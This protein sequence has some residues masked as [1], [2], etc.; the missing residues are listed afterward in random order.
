M[1]LACVPMTVPATLQ[2]PTPV[3]GTSWQ[4]PF[5]FEPD[6]KQLP[7]QQS[8]FSKQTSL[9]CKQYEMDVHFPPTQPPEQQSAF[10]PHALPEPR[11]PVVIAVHLPPEQRPL[12]HWTFDVHDAAVGLSGRHA[13]A[14]QVL[15]EPQ[16]PEQ[17]SEPV[18]HVTP[19][20]KHGPVR[21]PQTFG[22]LEPQMPPPGQGPEPTP[23]VRR[24]PQPSGTKPQ[25][26]PAQAVA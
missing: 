4:V 9:T 21:V 10:V 23:H 20:L 12:Q 1:P 18:S 7:V 26:R 17:Q 6:F 2:P 24:P 19:V 8:P 15:F 13:F 14:W 5:W 11:Q 22:W 3:S 16:L 25:L